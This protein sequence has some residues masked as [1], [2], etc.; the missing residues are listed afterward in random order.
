MQNLSEEAPSWE[1][2]AIVT[3]C[4]RCAAEFG[5][6]VWKHHCRCCGRVLCDSCSYYY[7]Y[8]REVPKNYICP[9]PDNYERTDPF[10]C[11]LNCRTRIREL[12]AVGDNINDNKG[13]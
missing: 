11:C 7:M 6:M 3:V 8:L 4:N 9:F 1:D 10:R 13:K 2:D 5:P 12:A